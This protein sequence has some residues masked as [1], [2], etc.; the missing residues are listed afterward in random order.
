M[1][2]PR[3]R[4]LG[5]LGGASLLGVTGTPS[6]ARALTPPPPPSP[7]SN[8]HP[9][10]VTET[11]DMSWTTK[12]SGK[13]KAVPHADFVAH[14]DINTRDGPRRGGGNGRDGFF[15]LKFKDRLIPFHLVAFADEKV[16]DSSRIRAFTQRWKF[17]VHKMYP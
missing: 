13:Y 6:V 10:P 11:W 7:E 12:V 4:F 14:F 8:E 2:T 1:S 9:Q 3:R 15:V 16:N 17:Q 5:L